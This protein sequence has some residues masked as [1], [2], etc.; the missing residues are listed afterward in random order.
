M[1]TTKKELDHIDRQII[2]LA[3]E[4]MTAKEIAREMK[5]STRSIEYRFSCMKKYYDC[6]SVAQLLYKLKTEI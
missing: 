3:G 2:M 5:T 6:R 1:I 4:G